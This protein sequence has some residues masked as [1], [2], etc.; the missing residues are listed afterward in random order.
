MTIRNAEIEFLEHIEDKNSVKCAE[1]IYCKATHR[2]KKGYVKSDLE[3]FCRALRDINYDSGYGSQELFG[4]IWYFGGSWSERGEYDG[5]E[6]WEYKTCP[7]I[8]AELR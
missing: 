2:L 6:W 1:I 8:P 4:T 5:S 3:L 7:K